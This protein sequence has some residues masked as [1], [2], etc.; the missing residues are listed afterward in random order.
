MSAPPE[1]MRRLAEQQRQEARRDALLDAME[2]SEIENRERLLAF[3][4]LCCTCRP[5]F[6]WSLRDVPPQG[7]CAV[8]GNIVVTRSGRVM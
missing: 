1:I 7:G 3:A 8:H 6:D 5:W 2:A 4:W